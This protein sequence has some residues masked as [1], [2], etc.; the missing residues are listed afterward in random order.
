MIN[1]SKPHKLIIMISVIVK[2]IP[3]YCNLLLFSVFTKSYKYFSKIDFIE[4]S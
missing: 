4:E 2:R 1:Y 3:E